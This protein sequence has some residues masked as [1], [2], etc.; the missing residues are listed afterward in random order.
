LIVA[1]TNLIAYLLIR[2]NFTELSESILKRDADWHAPVLWRSEMRN[3]LT[4]YI[5]RKQLPLEECLDV[6]RRAEALLHGREH[7]VPSMA[8]M[9]LVERSQCSAYDCEFVALAQQL[10]SPL[11][12]F[13]DQILSQFPSLAR[14]PQNF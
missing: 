10:R 3:V 7:H 2:G 14:S 13:D 6:M 5:R 12:T 11:I 1:D 9:Q 4:G 8:V